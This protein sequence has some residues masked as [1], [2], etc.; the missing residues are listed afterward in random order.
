MDHDLPDRFEELMSF[1][2]AWGLPTE[3]ARSSQRWKSTAADFEAF[4]NAFIPRLEDALA[5]L[6]SLGPTEITG[7]AANLLNLTLAFAEVAPHVELYGSSP[8]VPFSFEAV[9]FA[10]SH[11]TVPSAD[12]YRQEAAR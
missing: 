8:T 7:A 6:G 5:Y 9:R 10:A 2:P 12:L 1:V 3:D 11:G 4:Y